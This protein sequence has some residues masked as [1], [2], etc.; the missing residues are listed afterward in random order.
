MSYRS[1]HISLLMLL[2]ILDICMIN[3]SGM[4]AFWLRCRTA[5]FE[6]ARVQVVDLTGDNRPVWGIRKSGQY[7]EART[8]SGDRKAEEWAPFSSG[9]LTDGI[10]SQGVELPAEGQWDV[11]ID[12]G[13]VCVVDR[14][15]WAVSGEISGEVELD[16]IDPV[17]GDSQPLSKA[18]YEPHTGR[19]VVALGQQKAQRLQAR[20]VALDPVRVA[21][22]RVFGYDPAL[23]RILARP[24]SEV[25]RR[26]YEYLLVLWNAAALL[27]LLYCG[28]YRITRS[29]ELLDDF[30]IVMKS[31]AFAAVGVVV[32]LFL[33]R[34]YQEVTYLGFEYSR[35][36]VILGAVFSTMLLTGNRAVVDAAH[37][38]FL[39]RGYGIRKVLIVGAGPPGQRIVDRLRTHYW[40]AYDPAGF[41]DDN[42]QLH[43]KYIQGLPVLGG[44]E[45]LRE[46][47]VM[48]GTDEVIVA[49]PNSSH[50][51]VRDIVGRCHSEHL[52]FRILPDLFEVMSSQVQVGAL[53]GVPVLD[54]DD[55]YLGQWDRFL[56]RGMDVTG[57]LMG[58]ILLSP[59]FASLTAL[60][61]LT[62]RGPIFFVQGRVGENG[63]T[64]PFYKF[65]TMDVVSEEEARREREASYKELIQSNQSGGKIVNRN[66]V[67]WI[68]AF[69]RRFSLDELPQV[70]NVIRGE[71]SLVGPRPPIPY[72]VASY[73]TWHME[74]FKGKPGITGLWQVS[75][76]AELPFEEMVKLDIY[77]LKTWSLWLDFKIML[78]T[79]PTVLSG[80]GAQ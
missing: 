51:A 63:K 28:A 65:R 73:N 52:K 70:F 40:L 67:T 23:P 42:S 54:L 7:R 32:I 20:F 33:H 78:K 26:P 59:L 72:E 10:E 77:Y 75:G 76:R 17:T 57:A 31:V 45:R 25:P 80:R 18:K 43:G 8:V 60:I 68:G 56:K 38:H 74:R 55:H 48:V 44:T 46:F 47:A 36:V 34:G 58:L 30:C 2:L 19:L 16:L 50:K 27:A 12:L 66:R 61:K 62:S 11:E 13:T 9:V 71:M 6:E 39:K 49:L 3:L 24:V 5:L 35:V 41:V 15:E 53:D 64:F 4:A 37:R 21:E 14:V 22:F 1:L 79:I 69:M 29:L